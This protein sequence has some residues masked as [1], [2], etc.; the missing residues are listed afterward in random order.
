M[1]DKAPFS[2]PAK[3]G[4]DK[5]L[6]IGVRAK[7][8]DMGDPARRYPSVAAIGGTIMNSIF[9]DSLDS[10]YENME[11]V[12]R[13]VR[14]TPQRGYRPLEALLLRPS[15]D[16]GALAMNY[17]NEIPLVVRQAVH[18]FGK[19]KRSSSDFL[20]YITFSGGYARTLMT[21]GYNDCK[22]NH[23]ALAQFFKG[24]SSAA[25]TA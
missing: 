12:N 5:I 25:S 1:R 23:E 15:R 10:D 7:D 17:V 8:S 3:L 9:L 14:L 13:L 6:A 16:L 4:V 24:S 19:A 2:P 11:R 22:L 18:G 21:L 20:S